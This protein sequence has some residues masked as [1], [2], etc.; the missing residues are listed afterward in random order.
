M[1][2]PIKQ[3]TYKNVAFRLTTTDGGEKKKKRGHDYF[4]K[5][6]AE[7]NP[8]ISEVEPDH[9]SPS[10]DTGS[11]SSPASLWCSLLQLRRAETLCTRRHAGSPD[12]PSIR[13]HDIPILRKIDT[14]KGLIRWQIFFFFLSCMPFSWKVNPTAFVCE[15]SFKSLSHC[16]RE[17][18]FLLQ[19]KKK[20]SIRYVST[21]SVENLMCLLSQCFQAIICGL[22]SVQMCADLVQQKC[23]WQQP[24]SRPF[25]S[26]LSQIEEVNRK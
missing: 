3:R 17:L 18:H 25:P 21:H 1:L 6:S 26:L 19:G 12:L 7:I 16:Q 13:L 15:A 10:T 8:V 22:V 24:L 5:H 2:W 20:V 11:L 9:A 23:V 4:L 14:T